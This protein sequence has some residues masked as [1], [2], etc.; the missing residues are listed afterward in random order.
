MRKIILLPQNECCRKNITQI[1][2]DKYHRR[3]GIASLLLYEMSKLNR[4]A[5]TKLLN[6]DS[7]CSSVVNFLKA[8]KVEITIKQFEM[9]K[10][11]V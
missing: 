5:R 2:I 9:L 1:A 6:S 3:K 8:K 7:L 10:E 4:N 11:L